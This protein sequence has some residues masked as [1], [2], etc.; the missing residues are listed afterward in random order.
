MCKTIAM[1]IYPGGQSLDVSGPLEVFA[2]A[3]RQASE[4]RPGSP[5]LYRPLL[6]G[7]QCGAVAMASG[8]R[9][10]AER[11]IGEIDGSG[12]DTLLISGGMGD[13][14]DRV[15]ADRLVVDWVRRAATRVRRTGSICS[16][17]L[18][19]AEAGL[20]DGREATT[21]W[22]DAAELERRYPA[23]RVAADAIYLNDGPV[24]TS[25]GVT[26]GMDL[27]LAMVAADHG[28]SLAL[29]VAKRLV[30]VTRRS[31]GQSQFSHQLR[32]E[33]ALP[34]FA[35]LTDW[36]RANLR[37]RI[38]VEQLA[39]RMHLS[40]RQVHR[41]FVGAVGVSPQ[42][43]IEQLRTEA[44]KSLLEHSDKELKQIASDCG[45]ASEEAMR[46]AFLRQHGVRPGDYRRRFAPP[47]R[48]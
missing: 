30:M 19:L 26:A 45:F 48:G 44:A 28:S 4:D 20:L 9:L 47:V 23:V 27:A 36:L 6:V 42:R 8:L 22:L 39:E 3:S 10:I 17:A 33:Y 21:H 38:G 7:A 15:C 11:A 13:A 35:A 5:P 40:T 16:G 43:Y 37:R 32:A 12:I 34:A 41:R 18:L 24:W 2:V 31:G 14:L 25:A 29:K 46:R 1:L